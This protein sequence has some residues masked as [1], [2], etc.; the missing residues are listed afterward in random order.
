MFFKMQF[1]YTV[2]RSFVHVDNVS[3][4]KCNESILYLDNTFHVKIQH[5]NLHVTDNLGLFPLALY[6]QQILYYCKVG[7]CLLTCKCN[8]DFDEQGHFYLCHSR[9]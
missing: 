7:E 3:L 5:Q 4:K 6:T 1:L 2:N 9:T 8:K